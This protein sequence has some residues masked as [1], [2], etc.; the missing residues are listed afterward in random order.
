MIIVDP[1]DVVVLMGGLSWSANSRLTRMYPAGVGAGYFLQVAA[2]VENRPQHAVGEAVVIFL[3]VVLERSIKDVGY[4]LE[5]DR[6]R[7]GVGL[8]SDLAAPAEP[9]AIAV[10][11]GGLHGDS[12]AASAVAPTPVPALRRGWK[13]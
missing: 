13:R 9:Q 4:V 6:I 7:L 10:L 12:Q 5:F 3:Q 1:D 11:E 2:V 8:V